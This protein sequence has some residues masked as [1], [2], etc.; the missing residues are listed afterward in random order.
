MAAV[1]ELSGRIDLSVERPF[2]TVKKN[3]TRFRDNDVLFA[4]ITPSMENGKVAV[5]RGLRSGRGCGT[6]EFHIVRPAVDVAP[7]YL[8]LFLV[9]SRYRQTAKRNMQGAVGQQRVPADFIRES[10]IPVAP[11]NEQC[12]IVSRIDELFSRI[13]E[14]EQALKRVAKLVE[15]YRQSVLKAA[16]TGELTR[17]W[18]EARKRAGEPAES[19]AALLACILKARR[20]AWEKAEL[21][22]LKAKG[23][24]P[25]DDHWKQKYQEPAPPDT[26]DLPKLPEGW[27]WTTVEQLC[28]VDTGATPKRGNERY[29]SGGTIR[30]ITSGAVNESLIL[31][32]QE[33]I[34]EAAIVETNAKVFPVGSLIV[35]MYGEGKTRGK[36]SELGV[37]AATN[38]ACAALVCGHVERAT[39]AYLR[40]FLEKN[41][42][43]LRAAAAGG[44]QPNLNLAII[45]A[46]PVALPPLIE[47]GEIVSLVDK[48]T[49][50]CGDAGSAVDIE[51]RRAIALRQ[52]A[53]KAA[54]SGQLVPQNPNDE[55]ASKLLER[56]AAERGNAAPPHRKRTKKTA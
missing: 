3:F 35:A 28:F 32:A 4:K 37:D 22:K 17:D 39:K 53:L 21:A 56:I 42:L 2:A 26:T 10:A 20:A 31:D 23:K 55:P 45:K 49:V 51:V 54:F 16:V 18:R 30:W 52:S 46:L 24:T 50:N 44:V 13:D 19:G 6:T 38:Q 27:A 11:A 14:G 29:Y 33:R 36:V 8:R 7:D 15:R 41:Y 5:A 12:R 9:Q 43:S 47:Q 25:N 48:A 1:E 40:A 34:T